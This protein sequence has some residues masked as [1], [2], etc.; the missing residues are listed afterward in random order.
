MTFVPH[1]ALFF[2]GREIN[3]GGT[4]FAGGSFARVYQ[5]H[6]ASFVYVYIYAFKASDMGLY[7]WQS[8][9]ITS[10]N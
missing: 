2:L 1:G 4:H 10:I 3:L 5:C 6:F 7:L 8:T 9:V